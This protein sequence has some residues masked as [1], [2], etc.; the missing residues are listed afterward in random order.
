MGELVDAGVVLAAEG[1]R[2]AGPGY[3]FTRLKDLKPEMIAE[4]TANARRSAE[5]FAADAGSRLGGIRRANQGVF[6][7]QPRDRAPAI[8]EQSQLHKTVRV[9]SPIEYALE[10]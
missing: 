4:A 7:I 2:H 6:V 10:D 9:V 8:T 3:L 1:G 5:Q